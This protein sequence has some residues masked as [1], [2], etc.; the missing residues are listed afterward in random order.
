MLR[1]Q[2]DIVLGV[3]ALPGQIGASVEL[4]RCCR[5]GGPLA[6]CPVVVGKV[7]CM[8]CDLGSM[9]GSAW[10]LCEVGGGGC[11]G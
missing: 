8:L 4:G 10:V 7:C 2:Y 9:F 6:S 3:Q 1:G 11:V 5:P